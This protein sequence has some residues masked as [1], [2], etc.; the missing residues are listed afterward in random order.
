LKAIVRK[1][2]K[3]E[4]IESIRETCIQIRS[5]KGGISKVVV[6]IC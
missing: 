6:E 5:G 3:L 2:L 4:D 1:V